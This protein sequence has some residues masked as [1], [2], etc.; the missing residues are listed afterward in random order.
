M[1]FSIFSI[2]IKFW[3]QRPVTVD[4]VLS[5]NNSCQSCNNV[6]SASANS[7]VRCTTNIKFIYFSD[8]VYFLYLHLLLYLD[9]HICIIYT[10]CGYLICFNAKWQVRNMGYGAKT[11]LDSP[12][13][14]NDLHKPAGLYPCH[15]QGG[16]Q[17]C[18]QWWSWCSGQDT[19][20]MREASWGTSPLLHVCK[21]H[22]NQHDQGLYLLSNVPFVSFII[23]TS[24]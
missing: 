13:R 4:I 7:L 18:L 23:L 1:C 2:W 16:N 11:C 14:K 8:S 22:E 3:K 17:V 20:D 24:S 5:Y 9:H 6:W 10:M 19:S 21:H 12:A 15:G